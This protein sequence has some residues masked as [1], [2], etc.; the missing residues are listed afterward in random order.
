MDTII[1]NENSFD[2]TVSFIKKYFKKV[3]VIRNENSHLASKT[4]NYFIIILFENRNT[5]FSIKWN[6]HSSTLYFG[7]ITKIKETSFQ[8]VFTKINID[9]C[10]PVEIGNN[11]NV[12]FWQY[13]IIHPHDNMS[14]EISPLRL[15]VS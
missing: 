4:Q 1:N 13:E 6:Y 5:K 14:N 2:K 3:K 11:K 12:V 9:E 15:P 8:Y 10:Y 7:D